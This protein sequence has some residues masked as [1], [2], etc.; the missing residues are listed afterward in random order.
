MEKG[1]IPLRANQAGTIGLM[2]A[3]EIVNT[4]IITIHCEVVTMIKE[5]P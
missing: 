2:T 5:S 3:V 1:D 4:S